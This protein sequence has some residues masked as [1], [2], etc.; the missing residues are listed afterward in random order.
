LIRQSGESC[1]RGGDKTSYEE[2]QFHGISDFK[3]LVGATTSKNLK[4]PDSSWPSIQLL[5]IFQKEQ[6]T[7]AGLSELFVR[8]EKVKADSALQAG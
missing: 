4:W 1:H 8:Q 6:E 2:F 3:A 7:P 5:F